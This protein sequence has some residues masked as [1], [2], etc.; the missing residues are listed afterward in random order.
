MAN[1]RLS[2]TWTLRLTV[3]GKVDHGVASQRHFD[4]PS[5]VETVGRGPGRTVTNSQ[6]LLGN[7][8]ESSSEISSFML[9]NLTQ[10]WAYLV[11][12][13]FNSVTNHTSPITCQ[14]IRDVQC[15]RVYK[16]AYGAF[17]MNVLLFVW[18]SIHHELGS[19][20]AARPTM[21]RNWLVRDGV[22]FNAPST[23]IYR[24]FWR[25]LTL[26]RPLLPWWV[27]L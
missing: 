8:Q 14:V 9:Q 18:T 6:M 22:E 3:R 12:N 17:Y 21:H 2:L 23:T 26:W 16:N 4:W 25:R 5:T 24:S 20:P 13:C 7:L 11:K 15:I 19:V 27:Q 10:N 1:A